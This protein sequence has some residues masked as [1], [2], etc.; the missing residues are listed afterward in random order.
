MDKKQFLITGGAGFLGSHLSRRLINEGHAVI[1]IDDLSYGFMENIADLLPLEDFV[2]IKK[3]ITE[4]K[5]NDIDYFYGVDTVF[6]M[7][8]ISALHTCEDN[9]AWCVD[10][11]T[12][13]TVIVLELARKAGVDKFFFSGTSAVYERTPPEIIEANNGSL[14]EDSDRFHPCSMYA[15]AKESSEK[16]VR[17]FYPQNHVI[18]RYHNVFGP[19]MNLKRDLPPLIGNFLKGIQKNNSV[20]IFGDGTK[21]RDYIFYEDVMDFHLKGLDIFSEIKGGTYNIGTGN[22]FSVLEILDIVTQLMNT[23]NVKIKWEPDRR[24]ESILTMANIDRERQLF[25]IKEFTSIDIGIQKTL[26]SFI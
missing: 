1:S 20:I 7:A 25:D 14:I 21:K 12:K 16:F 19:G 4:L 10:V 17:Y 22:S 3:N 24:W 2:F 9:P 15:I 23:N 26:E 11:N 6:H 13:G 8:A 18:Y 5:E